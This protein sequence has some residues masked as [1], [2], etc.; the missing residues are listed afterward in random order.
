[1]PPDEIA[2]TPVEQLGK[3]MLFDHTLSN[4]PGYGCATC[5]L[6]EAGFT[7]PDSLVNL[8]GARLR[9]FSRV[10]PCER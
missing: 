5:H 4:P 9:E 2:L 3:F 6:P 8:F 7:G 1:M 10:I